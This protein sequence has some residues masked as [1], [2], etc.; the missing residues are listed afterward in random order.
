VSVSDADIAFA[1]DLFADLGDVSGRKM[2]GGLGL[3]RDGTIF[4]LVSSSG[5]VYL[6][7]TGD[8]ASEL[9]ESQSEQFHNMPYWSLPD[10]ALEDPSLS[11]ELAKQAIRLLSDT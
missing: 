11:V 1:L 6:K 2:F 10:E 7:A 9:Q 4:G 5:T 3:Y 8:F